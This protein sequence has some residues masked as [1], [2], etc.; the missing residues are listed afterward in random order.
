M[1]HLVSCRFSLHIVHVLY[2]LVMSNFI[3]QLEDY[4]ENAQ[5]EFLLGSSN[6]IFSKMEFAASHKLNVL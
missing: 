5:V 1:S 2:L 3:C 6:I 4:A